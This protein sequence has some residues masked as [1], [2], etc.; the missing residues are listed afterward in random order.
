MAAGQYPT[1]GK[2][3]IVAVVQGR[4]FQL[5]IFDADGRR[6]VDEVNGESKLPGK[7]TQ[8]AEMKSSNKQ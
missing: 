5:R 4:S 6:V 2:N 3:L 1:E 7:P 8:F